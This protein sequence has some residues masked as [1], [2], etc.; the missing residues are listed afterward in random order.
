VVV[1][2]APTF[3]WRLP[4]GVL[5]LAHV[6]KALHLHTSAVNAS[7]WGVFDGGRGVFF[8]LTLHF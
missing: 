5:R 3:P 8:K 6:E 7:F 2:T 4:I 1:E